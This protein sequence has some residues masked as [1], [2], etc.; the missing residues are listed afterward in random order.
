MGIF[1]SLWKRAFGKGGA[2][3]PAREKPARPPEKGRAGEKPA[4][5]E[6]NGTKAPPEDPSWVSVSER[7]ALIRD[8]L[9]IRADK[10]NVLDGID[11]DLRERLS[12]AV[13]KKIEKKD[14]ED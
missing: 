8:A 5:A 10:Q 13:I 12:E 2:P 14:G 1:G 11:G 6:D 7:E 3:S 4:P 9:R